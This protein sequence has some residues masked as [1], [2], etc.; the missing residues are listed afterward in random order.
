M[1]PFRVV[2]VSPSPFQFLE[3]TVDDAKLAHPDGSLRV[4]V[5]LDAESAHDEFSNS[6]PLIEFV[7]DELYVRHTKT[8]IAEQYDVPEVRAQLNR[9]TA[10]LQ[11]WCR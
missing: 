11:M 3:V 6:A 9:E 8:S 2:R 10:R 7:R 5:R 1:S 4:D